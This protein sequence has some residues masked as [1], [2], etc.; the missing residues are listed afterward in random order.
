LKILGD[1]SFKNK[2]M[3]KRTIQIS[4]PMMGQEEWE[5]LK[6]PIFSGWLTQGPKVA[7]LQK[8]FSER[9]Q[10]KHALAVSN[11]TTAL[12]LALLAVGVK[13]GDEVLV[14]AFTW[15]STANAVMY[16]NA[17]PVFVDVD[18][19]SFNMDITKIKNKITS[20]TTAIIPVH[21]FG[22]CA[23]VDAIKAEFPKLKI[24]EDAACAAGSALRG[25][26]A[27]SLGDVG[28]FSL[29]PRKS[30]TTGEGG[31]LTT[32][33]DA[34]ASAMDMMRNH[35]A[36]ISEEQ[37]HKGPKPYILPDFDMVGFNYRMTD[38]QGAVGVVQIKKLD[39]FIDDRQ[40]WADFYTK[41]LANISWLR[42]PQVPSGYKHGWQSYVLYIDEAKS[43]MKRN[44]IMEYL[45]QQGI[46]TRPGTHAVHMLGFYSKTFNIKPHDYPGAFASNEYSMSIPLHNKMVKEDYEYVVEKIKSIK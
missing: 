15:V 43:P 11:C 8:L 40:H 33:N 12:H 32:N 5:A 46:S 42:T 36:S 3:I 21:L 14:P 27:G 10:V 35:G 37:R 44:D 45:Q 30:V 4:Q 31:M 16:C 38:L 23:D 24:V 17:I 29:H 19:V 39:T 1:N 25:K 18:P 9:H 34:Y 2:E 26:P 7:E 20:K 6:E 13:P 41:E 28:C 22:L